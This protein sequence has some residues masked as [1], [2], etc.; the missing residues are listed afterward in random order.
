VGGGVGIGGKYYVKPRIE[1]RKGRDERERKKTSQRWRFGGGDVNLSRGGADQGPGAAGKKHT[2]RKKKLLT[3]K[4][5]S[6][7]DRNEKGEEIRTKN[8]QHPEGRGRAGACSGARNQNRR[9][10][11][12][13]QGR[14]E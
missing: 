1:T 9:K 11:K 13:G 14:N 3:W 2:A 10:N 5:K 4:K 6:E 7:K 8:I 12:K